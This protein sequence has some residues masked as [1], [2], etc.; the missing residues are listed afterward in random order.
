MGL[1]R[2]QRPR[3]QALVRARG[4]RLLPHLIPPFLK[5]LAQPVPQ[6]GPKRFV[7]ATAGQA[8]NQRHKL[9]LEGDLPRGP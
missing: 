7:V 5:F 2:Q 4:E 3:H 9:L 8:D 1:L 6:L